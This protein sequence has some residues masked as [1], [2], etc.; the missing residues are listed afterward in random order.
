MG[1]TLFHKLFKL[2]YSSKV[3]LTVYYYGIST[4]FVFISISLINQII[5]YILINYIF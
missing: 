5:M 3:K 4:K 1:I 2:S